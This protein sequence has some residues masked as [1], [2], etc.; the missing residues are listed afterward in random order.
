MNVQIFKFSIY[1]A[2]CSLSYLYLILL[3]LLITVFIVQLSEAY[4]VILGYKINFDFDLTWQTGG[5]V[6]RGAKQ[7]EISYT[8]ELNRKKDRK[9]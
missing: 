8:V 4:F 9:R 1:I 5:Q 7:D 3:M 6:I 2:L